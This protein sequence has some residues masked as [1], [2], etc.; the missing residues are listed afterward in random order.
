MH[1]AILNAPGNYHTR[2]WAGALARAGARITVISM[3]SGQADHHSTIAIHPNRK[4]S[5]LRYLL[6]GEALSALLKNLKVDLVHPLNVTPFGVW[7][8]QAGNH[9]C[10]PM[11]MGADIL[12]YDTET[13]TR[14]P[15]DRTWNG[16]R[17]R[18][19]RIAANQVFRHFVQQ[20]LDFSDHI[21]CDNNAVQGALTSSFRLSQEK[22]TLLRWGVEPEMFVQETNPRSGVFDRLGIQ[23][24]DKLILSPRGLN[25]F[26][27]ADIIIEAFR[28][29]LDHLPD[30]DLR[31]VL[32]ASG[33]DPD[34]AILA[35]AKEVQAHDQ[36]LVVVEKPVA[37]TEMPL[38]WKQ[39]RCF[40]SIPVYDGFSAALA[41]GMYV[42]S[43]PVV[44]DIPGNR[45]VLEGGGEMSILDHTTAETLAAGII[46][47][48][49]DDPR[50]N[51]VRARNRA[52]VERNAILDQQ[53][54]YFI[55]L[56]SRIAL[57]I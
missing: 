57:K 8:M 23:P 27:Q 35:T 19:V 14:I 1:I 38:L 13:T 2:K 7:A 24:G 36:R 56:A 32:L 26:Y 42:G 3:E 28:M 10:I 12:E 4:L 15:G 41:E 37:R 5:Y 47:A 54:A 51:L 53:A 25:R 16:A 33:Y 48:W 29:V 17:N 6:E 52:W 21:I 40:I 9:P 20:A 43:I 34:P 55:E 22:V 18:F 44:N 46:R 39:S 30:P 49:S 50:W 45:E 31:P 11:A